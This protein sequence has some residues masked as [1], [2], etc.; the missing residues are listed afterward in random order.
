MVEMLRYTDE[1][2]ELIRKMRRK[3]YA[4]EVTGLEDGKVVGNLYPM[5]YQEHVEY[6]KKMSVPVEKAV[7]SVVRMNPVI[8]V[9]SFKKM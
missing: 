2:A 5:D 1:S 4:I 8:L 3:A 9:D 6:M 7:V